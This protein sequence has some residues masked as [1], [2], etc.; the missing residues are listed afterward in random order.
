MPRRQLGSVERAQQAKRESRSLDFKEGFDPDV[1]SEWPELVKDFVAMANSGGGLIVFGVRNNGTAAP[2]SVR[3]ILALDPAV[4]TDKVARYT[5]VQFSDFQVHKAKRG[6]KSVAV[7]EIGA[8]VDAPIAF[9][10]VGTYTLSGE[11]KQQQKT[12]F[13][14]G[15]VYFRH[16]AKSEPGTTEDLRAFI[17]RRLARV[18]EQWLG[19]IR[20]VVEA[21]E[22]ARL[23]MVEATN[24][25]ERGIPTEIRLTDDPRAP[26]YGKLAPDRTHPFRQKELIDEINHRLPKGFEVNTYD[27]LSV[28][29]VNDITERTHPQ[30]AYEPKWGSPQY[31]PGFVDWVL[32][33]FR[34]DRTFFETAKAEYGRRQQ[35]R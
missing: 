28:R 19:G 27:M 8:A 10:Q 21:P 13:S 6:S 12:A 25:D 3:S 29:R 26:V 22:G 9:T 11:G 31:S 5:G 14:K 4:I 20:H 16:G 1:R 23:A 35:S 33:Q 17:E 15:T 24:P 34:R 32:E 7:I 2:G 30:F 18:R